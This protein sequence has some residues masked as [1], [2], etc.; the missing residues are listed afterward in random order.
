MEQERGVREARRPKASGRCQPLRVMCA[1]RYGLLFSVLF[2]PAR[3]EMEM[4]RAFLW[5]IFSLCGG[6]TVVKALEDSS[7][8]M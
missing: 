4:D 5:G 1:G 8:H 7:L 2:Q 3:E 6:V